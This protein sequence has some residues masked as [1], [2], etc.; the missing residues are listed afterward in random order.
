MGTTEY[1][2]Q[3]ASSVTMTTP[4]SES[5]IVHA[6][7]LAAPRFEDIS[8]D[9]LEAAPILFSHPVRVDLTWTPA[10]NKDLLG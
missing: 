3:P 6:P 4:F 9:R 8:E 1:I 7:Q 5:L 2:A 10:A